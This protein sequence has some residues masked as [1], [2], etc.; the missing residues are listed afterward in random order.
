[1]SSSIFLKSILFFMRCNKRKTKS[2]RQISTA[3]T[4]WNISMTTVA[5]C[6][7]SKTEIASSNNS[8]IMVLMLLSKNFYCTIWNSAK[9]SIFIKR[10][11]MNEQN[12]TLKIWRLEWNNSRNVTLLNQS[13]KKHTI[14]IGDRCAISMS[15]KTVWRSWHD[16]V[17]CS[18][19]KLRKISE[20]WVKV[21]VSTSFSISWPKC[22]D[23]ST[24]P[25]NC[26]LKL[27]SV[28]QPS[29]NSGPQVSKSQKS[30]DKNTWIRSNQGS[31]LKPQKS[32]RSC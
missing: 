28:N 3:D 26:L 27:R 19:I 2:K 7:K 11:F 23:S 1:M 13:S 31:S 18:Q 5:V 32:A 17:T 16:S 24:Q 10:K 22:W 14:T 21:E 12:M 15:V 25:K 29:T 20:R 9:L 4:A 30:R 8:K 6:L